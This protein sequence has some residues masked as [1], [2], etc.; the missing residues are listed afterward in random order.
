M[1]CWTDS[2]MATSCWPKGN[3]RPT[4]GHFVK[5]CAFQSMV[6]HQDS[7]VC[8]KKAT[9]YVARPLAQRQL[10]RQTTLHSAALFAYSDVPGVCG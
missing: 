8:A 2:M 6:S 10:L 9:S 1:N 5:S 4:R 3:S 7:N